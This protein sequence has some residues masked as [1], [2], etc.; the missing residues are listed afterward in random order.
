MYYREQLYNAITGS[1]K[2]ITSGSTYSTSVGNYVLPMQNYTA[3]ENE[4]Q[5][6]V[7]DSFEN[8]IDTGTYDTIYPQDVIFVFEIFIQ[9]RKGTDTLRILRN[10]ICDVEKN[11]GLYYETLMTNFPS[12]RVTITENTI[13][14]DQNE[15]IIGTG[16]ITLNIHVRQKS[17]TPD[18]Q[19]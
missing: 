4:Y 1:L 8:Y 10:A 11:I 19:C 18:V 2:N 17:F 9:V 14:I 13:E 12:A 3:N 7:I 15:S 16:K 6:Y 5:L